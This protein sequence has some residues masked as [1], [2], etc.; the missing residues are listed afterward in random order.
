M[1]ETLVTAAEL[2]EH[3]ADPDWC[4]VDCRYD[5]KDPSAGRTEYA[6]GHIPGA[7][8][9]D[10]AD[11]LSAPRTATSGR[12]PLP[13]AADLAQRFA[14]LGIDARVQVVAYDASQGLYAARAWWLLR[15]MGHRAAAVLDGGLPAW[16]A[17][18][19]ALV[20]DV[21]VRAARAFPWHGGE[22]PGLTAT[23]VARELD[24]GR[25]CL[26]DVRAAERFEGRVEPLDPVAG[27]VPG[28]RN[29]PHSA[30]LD[31]DGRFRSAEDL[32]AWFTSRTDHAPP[33]SIVCMCGSGVTACHTLLALERAGLNGARLYAGSWS[34]W[35]RDPSRPV[36]TGPA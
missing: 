26:L 6:A 17:Q 20:R 18:G 32:R 12:H 33:P 5:L 35:C 28:A 31:P 2:A 30:S 27:H 34:E 21:P 23:D 14:D 9:L 16:Q 15:A 25:I 3:A 8:Y 29:L 1:F 7:A 36:A 10:L 22:L 4:V 13:A 11:D 19:G 24:A